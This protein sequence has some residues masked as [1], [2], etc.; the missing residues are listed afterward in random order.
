MEYER[1]FQFFADTACKKAE[2]DN[3]ESLN[4]V[5]KIYSLNKIIE[6]ADGY[7]SKQ[8]HSDLILGLL[9]FASLHFHEQA[10]L[11]YD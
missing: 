4:Q 9:K 8:Y 1:S 3:I 6:Q 2:P 10:Q 7:R 11:Y 5:L